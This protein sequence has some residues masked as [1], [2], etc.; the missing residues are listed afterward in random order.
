MP[1]SVNVQTIHPRKLAAA[2]REVPPGAVAAEWGP[3]LAKVWPYMLMLRYAGGSILCAEGE[4]GDAMYLIRT[5][6]AVVTKQGLAQSVA[7]LQEGDFFGEMALLL[8]E[9]RSATVAADG[10]LEVF[11]LAS[12]D[13]RRF[14]DRSPDMTST[15]RGLAEARR[16]ELARL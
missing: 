9:P 12:V 16:Q 13:Y 5:G 8:G 4:P 1:V 10:E 7:R 2:R 11:C 6:V 15:L 14:L 3:A